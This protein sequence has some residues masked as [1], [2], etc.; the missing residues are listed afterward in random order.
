MLVPHFHA[1]P[2]IRGKMFFIRLFP[3]LFACIALLAGCD[4]QNESVAGVP[5]GPP[6]AGVI[7]VK[8]RPITLITELSGRTA[9]Y[10]IAEVKPQ[11][12]GIILKG[13]FQEGS[14]VREGMPLYQIDPALYQAKV[15][16][17]KATLQKAD[18]N[19]EAAAARVASL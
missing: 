15:N 12:D 1:K 7:T 13:L 8:T 17:A 9:P 14:D 19:V 16:S 2:H 11:V 10:L 5:S 4:S 18:A 3:L 6:Q